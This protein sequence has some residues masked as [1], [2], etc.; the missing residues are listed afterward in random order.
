M[1]RR[2]LT[3]QS[4]ILLLV[5]AIV[6]VSVLITNLFLANHLKERTKDNLA[7]EILNIARMTA[8][9]SIVIDG[10]EDEAEREVVQTFA[11]ER[12]ELTNVGFV[13]VLDRNLI[14]LSHPIEEEVGKSFYNRQDAAAALEGEEYLSVE[15]GPLGVGMRV[16]T[17][18]YN[19]NKEQIGIVVVGVSLDNVHEQVRNGMIIVL[20]AAIIQLLF[21]LVGAIWISKYIKKI[22]FNLEPE[23][24][25]HLL[26]ERNTMLESVKEGILAVDQHG[27]ISLANKQATQL[28]KLPDSTSLIGQSVEHYM[29]IILN[30]IQDGK[31]VDNWEVHFFG[32]TVL[33]NCTPIYVDS[34]MVG[35]IAT[36]RDKTEIQ[37][38]MKEITGVKNYSDAL[39]ARSHEFKNKLHVILGMLHLKKYEELEQFIPTILSDYQAEKGFIIQYIKNPI[40]AGFLLGKNSKAKEK[41]IQFH[42]DETSDFS[43]EIEIDIMHD[44]ITII[45]SLVENAFDAV[46]NREEKKVSLYIALDYENQTII[47][48]VHDNGI[49]ISPDK[50]QT[51]FHKHYSTK[52][53]NRGYGLYLTNRA[54]ENLNGEWDI[55]TAIGKGT[56]IQVTI[57]IPNKG[58]EE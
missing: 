46:E 55:D 13:V 3:L 24:I 54:V 21:G 43:G 19:D 38:L 9:S 53:E 42:I 56:T 25:A 11:N 36:F 20:M 52:G 51:I 14:R 17:P 41:G 15:E 8:Q 33:V 27:N 34:H 29:P 49:G 35:A 57:T 22:L 30:V 23:E 50:L 40:L 6:L 5:F 45:G 39:R 12:K 44:L 1:H 47:V 32:K 4:I 10:L 31:S 18:V 2:K 48:T 37:Q 7:N 26:E 16:F 28:M 58:D